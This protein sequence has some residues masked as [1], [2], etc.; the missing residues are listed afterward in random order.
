MLSVNYFSDVL[1]VW[2]WIAQ[3]R[4]E[5]LSAQFGDSITIVHRYMDIFGAVDQKMDNQWGQ[6]GGYDGFAAHVSDAVDGFDHAPVHPETWRS[7]RPQTSGNAHLIIRA[8]G[9]AEGEAVATAFARNVRGAFFEHA[10]NIA[11]WNALL[12]LLD[13]DQ[14]S[15]QRVLGH[16][17]DGSAM[18]ALLSDY[19]AARNL[20]LKGSPS[21]VM[22]DER[23]ILYGNV[24]YR[25]LSANVEE[26][27]KQ[28]NHEA[29]WC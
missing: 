27:L 3:R 19:Q 13:D 16:I 24:G 15:R 10:V 26:L 4:V 17:E 1:C 25:V 9:L 8:V 21:Y 12:R 22:N 2:A 7:N 6:R 29:S 14:L 18:A 23:Q 11:D 28:V 20:N 5:E